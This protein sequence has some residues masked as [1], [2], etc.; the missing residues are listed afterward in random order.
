M[1]AA[2]MLE[3]GDFFVFENLRESVL[4]TRAEDGVVRVFYNVCQ[5]RGNQLK[6]QGAVPLPKLWLSW[7]AI[8]LDGSIKEIPEAH[9]FPQGVPADELNLKEA[10]EAWGIYLIS[11]DRI[12]SLN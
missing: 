12:S 10:D 2:A 8:Y 9:D 3:P 5:H 11:M 1:G 4:V 6:A 7:L